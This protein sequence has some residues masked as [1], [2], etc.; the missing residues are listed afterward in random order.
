MNIDDKLQ[1]LIAAEGL[2]AGFRETIDKVHL[3]LA[4]AI[5]RKQSNKHS[6]LVVGV[7]G[8]QGAG[9]STLTAFLPV[10]LTEPW[11]A[12]SEFFAGRYLPH[13]R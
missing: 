4:A 8:A 9:K 5:A 11:F 6:T 3:P 7:S 12:N 10:L 2:P 1:A 13:F